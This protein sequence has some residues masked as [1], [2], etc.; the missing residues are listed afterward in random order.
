MSGKMKKQQIKAQNT[1]NKI[2]NAA[3]ELFVQEEYEGVS[4]ASIVA[5][6]GC[7]VGAFYG[8]FKSKEALTTRIWLD[9]V[10]RLI[11]ESVEKGS[12][13]TDKEAFID[14]LIMH[15]HVARENPIMNA[16]YRHSRLNAEDRVELTSYASG[17]LGMIKN[18]LYNQAPDASDETL[19]SY[20]SI[21]HTVL[22]AHSQQGY[23]YEYMRFEDVVLKDTLLT[24]FDMCRDTK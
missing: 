8:H 6:A 5:K 21:I 22:N 19:W 1:R 13:I 17:F 12:R 24:F 16:L 4:V 20:A 9:T 14:Y 18:M 11:S 3:K 10:T 7:S 2:I 15:S 23:N